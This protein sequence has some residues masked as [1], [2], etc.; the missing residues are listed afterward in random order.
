MRVI[1]IILTTVFISCQ[2]I[3]TGNYEQLDSVTST[4]KEN[5]S[6]LLDSLESLEKE[7]YIDAVYNDEKDIYEIK[8]NIENENTEIF[9]DKVFEYRKQLSEINNLL[10]SYSSMLLAIA[11]EDVSKI[12]ENTTEF[13]TGIRSIEGK[14]DFND[15]QLEV[16]ENLLNEVERA[17]RIEALE[18][19]VENNQSLIE[20]F[21]T[22]ALEYI[23]QL[24]ELTFLIY[25]KRFADVYENYL[26][27]K[28]KD[29]LRYLLDLNDEYR[30]N[31]NYLKN[32]KSIYERLP[33]FHR[34]IISDTGFIGYVE[35]ISEDYFQEDISP[36]TEY[37]KN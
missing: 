2:S 19:I 33:A 14:P 23:K 18:K 24:E 21:S 20:E 6:T 37:I 25:D 1:I 27:E 28:E 3:N 9:L 4:L 16:L 15:D 29:K 30:R 12:Q 13:I 22:T 32:I 11:T 17:Y 10:S 5:S 31:V 35:H 34:D 7:N 26:T 36:W 8:Y